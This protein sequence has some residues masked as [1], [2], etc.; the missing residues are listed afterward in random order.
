MIE[1][2]SIVDQIEVSTSGGVGVR[3][4]L[5]LVE[6]GKVLSSKWHRVMIPSEISAAEQ[7][8]FVNEHLAMMGEAKISNA[9]IQRVG[10]FHKLAS[11]LPSENAPAKS[12]D[13]TVE[14]IK[15]AKA[16][17]KVKAT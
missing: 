1:H 7:M 12:I 14:E 9:D 8:A 17:R 13:E 2:K 10:L 6:D 5:Q 4:A 3:I 11:D 16:S 15:E